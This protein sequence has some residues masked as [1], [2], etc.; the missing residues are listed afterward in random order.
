MQ[1]K[2]SQMTYQ[3]PAVIICAGCGLFVYTASLLTCQACET[4]SYLACLPP[5]KM[6]Q[7]MSNFVCVGFLLSPFAPAPSR[8]L[9]NL[10]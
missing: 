4:I 2:A 9:G 1:F 8:S 7:I 3:H 5:D 10:V 6:E